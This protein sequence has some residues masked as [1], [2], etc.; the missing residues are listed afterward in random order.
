MGK[1]PKNKADR[2]NTINIY[3]VGNG[4]VI[5]LQNGRIIP[6]SNEKAGITAVTGDIPNSK[7]EAM[8]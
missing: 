8:A 5:L 7:T 3:V 2:T 6:D 1:T 4:I